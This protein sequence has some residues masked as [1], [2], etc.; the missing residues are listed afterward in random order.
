MVASEGPSRGNDIGRAH[1][2]FYMQGSAR[3]STPDVFCRESEFALFL[4]VVGELGKSTPTH[5]RVRADR[6]E[7][8]NIIHQQTHDEISKDGE[9]S[10]AG[11]CSDLRSNAS[12]RRN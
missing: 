6:A 12:N 9:R 3:E 11:S 8:S 1:Q 10:V 7:V 4:S 5:R 2:T